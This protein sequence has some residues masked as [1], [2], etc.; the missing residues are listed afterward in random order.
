[1]ALENKEKKS[2]KDLLSLD[3]FWNDP[4]SSQN[5][6]SSYFIDLP[7]PPSSVTSSSSPS[8]PFGTVSDAPSGAVDEFGTLLDSDLFQLPSFTLDSLNQMEAE[9]PYSDCNSS[10]NDIDT[11][12]LC[13]LDVD[14]L[15]SSIDLDSENI[16]PEIPLEDTKV[17]QLEDLDLWLSPESITPSLDLENLEQIEL[18]GPSLP[19]ISSDYVSLCVS[20]ASDTTSLFSETFSENSKTSSRASSVDESINMDCLK[21]H[22][23]DFGLEF[24]FNLQSLP[25]MSNGNEEDADLFE[26]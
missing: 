9:E 5:Q 10:D 12:V 11:A 18:D 21:S 25:L 17:N 6:K 19:T 16:M 1:M 7:T 15:T 14:A 22:D 24:D 2:D 20:P 13:E 3:S 26:F 4:L 8:P 23:M